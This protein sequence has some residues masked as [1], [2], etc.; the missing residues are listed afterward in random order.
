MINT[1]VLLVIAIATFLASIGRT[2]D[3]QA[4][5]IGALHPMTI[6]F[7]ALLLN[8]CLVFVACLLTNR[9]NFL[10]EL[11]MAGSSKE[12]K[13]LIISSTLFLASV[14]TVYWLYRREKFHIV[15][16]LSAVLML[17]FSIILSVV[18]LKEKISTATWVGIAIIAAGLFLIATNNNATKK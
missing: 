15:S 13:F 12:L 6:S 3:V 2:F 10:T 7:I 5:K 18:I 16:I 8:T 9:K 1:P 17:S 4:S 14:L 11:K